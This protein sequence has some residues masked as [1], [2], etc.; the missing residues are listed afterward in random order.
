MK[1]R[2]V[3]LAKDLQAA[4]RAIA[5]ARAVGIADLDISLMAR[6]DIEESTIDDARKE[7]DSDLFPALRRGLLLGALAGVV[8]SALMGI[9]WDVEATWPMIIIGG[10]VGGAI[11]GG[12]GSMLM[13]SAVPDPI[14]RRYASEIESGHVLVI[15]DGNPA[16]L[17]SLSAQ[18]HEAGVRQLSYEALSGAT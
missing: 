4:R 15:I 14:R 2:H 13:G 9:T 16:L 7:A 10:A 5:A 3:Y 18:M 11:V 1:T 6:G 12:L 8:V 17:A